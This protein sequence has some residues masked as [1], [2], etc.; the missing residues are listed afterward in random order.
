VWHQNADIAY[1]IDQYAQATGD[2]KF[3]RDKGLE[4][5]VDSA[6]FWMSR[7][8]EV[9]RA[10]CIC[11]I[12]WGRTSSTSTAKITVNSLMARRHLQLAARWL[13][14][15]KVTEPHAAKALIENW[16]LE[17]VR[18]RMDKCG[19][20]DGGPVGSRSRHPTTG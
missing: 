8:E 17:P 12:L 2:Y 5:L 7:L 13:K 20:T 14:S 11:M 16:R 10:S 9:R 18:L 4:M 19:P 1:A 3:M 6:R 15:I